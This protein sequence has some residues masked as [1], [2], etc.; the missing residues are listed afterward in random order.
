MRF[1][2]EGQRFSRTAA[3]PGGAPAPIFEAAT[4]PHPRNGGVALSGAPLILESIVAAGLK[5]LKIALHGDPYTFSVEQRLFHAATLYGGC[6]ALF[7]ALFNAARGLS[8]AGYLPLIPAGLLVLFV[9]FLSRRIVKSMRMYFGLVWF[10]GIGAATLL[11][12]QWFANGGSMGGAQYFFF[13]HVALILLALRGW[14]RYAALTLSLLLVIA[15]F[16]I[17]YAYPEW[18]Q[19]HPTEGQRLL[20]MTVSF[21][22]ALLLLGNV[23]LMVVASFAHTYERE[24]GYK[25]LFREDLTLAQN[26]QRRILEYDPALVAGYDFY[27]RH[28]PSAELSGDLYDVS[29]PAS[30]GLRIFLADARG[31]GINAALSAMLIKSEW[32]N[33]EQLNLSPGESLAELNRRILRRY[34]AEVSLS[35]VIADLGRDI[36]RYSSAGHPEQLLL[37]RGVVHELSSVGP[38]LGLVEDVRYTDQSLPLAPGA[39]LILFTDSLT[40]EVGVDGAGVGREWIARAALGLG[41]EAPATQ[42]GEALLEAFANRIG[43]SAGYLTI[44]DD[45]T[46]IVACQPSFGVD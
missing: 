11:A 25:T 6:F 28:L 46:L 37:N 36:L 13:V 43:Q 26:L 5:R 10:T 44:N 19:R 2:A 7:F 39:R 31:H 29:R 1:R 8:P 23:L 41:A 45:L 21:S 40:E 32:S 14:Q 33:L 16:Y 38:P 35:A 4:G 17:E 24:R 30:G 9:Y 12:E 18:I 42:T 20:G 27:L 15:L 34:G 3:G 22:A